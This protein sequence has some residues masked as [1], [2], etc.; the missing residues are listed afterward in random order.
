M[1]D[2]LTQASLTAI[3][4]NTEDCVLIESGSSNANT[5]KRLKMRIVPCYENISIAINQ[6]NK[7][8]KRHYTTFF[9]S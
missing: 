5:A 1:P 3:I 7:A 4:A 6:V 2:C 9:P 8:L